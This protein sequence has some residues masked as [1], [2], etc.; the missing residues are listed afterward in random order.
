ML[1]LRKS[2]VLLKKLKNLL[3][4]WRHPPLYNRPPLIS[5]NWVPVIFPWAEGGRRGIHT[6]SVSTSQAIANILD[7]AQDQ[8]FDL[9]NHSSAYDIFHKMPFSR[10]W[11]A[12]HESYPQW[13]ELAFQILLSLPQYISARVIFQ[14]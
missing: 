7:E 14:I 12:V 11:W 5:W 8:F 2:Q 3:R 6:K 4:I 9:R 13:S 10:F 1:C